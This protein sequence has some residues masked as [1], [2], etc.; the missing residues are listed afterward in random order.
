MDEKRIKFIVLIISFVL[1]L[2]GYFSRD[3]G[4]FANL[5]IISTFSSFAT[6]AFFEYKH[7]R[8]WKEKEEKLTLFLHD[9]TEVLASGL[10]LHKAVKVLS[11]N[12]YG[13]L[14][15]ELRFLA[16]QVSWNVPITKAL[17]RIAKKTM[18]SKKISTAFKILKEA[19]IS[20]GNTIAVLTSLSESF[21]MLQQVEKERKSIMS[22]YTLMIYT[23]SFIF[24]GV[25][26]MINR[27]LL[28][29][30]ANPQLV[31]T[32]TSGMGIGIADPCLFCSGVT[33][34][35]C[36]SLGFLAYNFLGLQAGKPYY[37]VSIFFLLS[38]IQAMFS[39]IV[40]GQIS[41]GSLR[42]GIKHCIILVA[43]VVASY[44]ILFRI[45]LIGV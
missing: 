30:F 14:N 34:N 11:K 7:Y 8:E 6:F 39:G 2:F 15:Q 12:D 17:D 36:D 32:G 40:A 33:C 45:G 24:L 1:I 3:I 18:K 13:S 23:I 5:L 42:A 38:V 25:V 26:V 21:E 43:V 4:V 44:L 20:G 28:P 31:G 9:L 37:Y 19:Y 35:V 16:N 29:I 27:L 41:E 10:P 22:K